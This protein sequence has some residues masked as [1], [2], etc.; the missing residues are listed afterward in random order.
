MTAL[1][2]EDQRSLQDLFLPSG[3]FRHVE[4]IEIAAGVEETFRLI[5]TLDFGSSRIVRLLLALRGMRTGSTLSL[6]LEGYEGFVLLGKRENRELLIGLIGQFWRPS[7]RLL[8]F[9]PEEFTKFVDGRY[10]K[11]TWRFTT[12]PGGNTG[13]HVETETRI[14]CLSESVRRKFRMYWFVIQPF[15]RFI[16]REILK[17]IKRVAESAHE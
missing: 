9:A 4:S 1:K 16:R 3:H 14:F 5:N 12:N 7:G 17:S 10:A 11:A 13:T 15:S 6:R 2:V 8:R